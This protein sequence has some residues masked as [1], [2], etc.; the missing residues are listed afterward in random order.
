MRGRSL[1]RCILCPSQI[2]QLDADQA[3]PD[4]R[5]GTRAKENHC[6]SLPRVGANAVETSNDIL[7]EQDLAGAI[8]A[9]L[10]P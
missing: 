5:V 2:R 1:C 6:C 4:T 10:E 3:Q 8:L 7:A 9:P